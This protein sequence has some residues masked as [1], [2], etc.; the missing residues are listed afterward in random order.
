MDG[1]ELLTVTS[2][3]VIDHSVGRN[4][5]NECRPPSKVKLRSIMV[6]CRNYQAL[7]SDA[8]CRLQFTEASDD[9]SCTRTVRLWEYKMRRSM[10]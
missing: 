3:F 2:F 7:L 6:K 5:T 9:A 8:R 1:L 4:L 10:R